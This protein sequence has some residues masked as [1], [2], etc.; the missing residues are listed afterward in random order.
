MT[1]SPQCE[2]TRDIAPLLHTGLYCSQAT[3]DEVPALTE[4]LIIYVTRRTQKKH[5]I[6]GCIA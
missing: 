3:S 1:Y 6:Y 5:Y 4:S 2:S